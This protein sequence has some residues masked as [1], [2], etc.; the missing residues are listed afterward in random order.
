MEPAER[1][2]DERA[3][4]DAGMRAEAT[5]LGRDHR[6]DDGRREVGER[7][8]RQAALARVGTKLGDDAPVAVE[9]RHVGRTM[10]RPHGGERRDRRGR[11]RVPRAD[12]RR[13]QQRAAERERGTQCG[14]APHGATSSAGF[15][16]SPKMSGA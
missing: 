5:I 2:G 11:D 10:A 13:D 14:A 1:R 12:R 4:V 3:R 9:Q 15:G 6:R 16:I 7:R 8:P